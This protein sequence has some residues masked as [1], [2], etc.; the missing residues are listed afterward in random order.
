MRRRDD[1]VFGSSGFVRALLA[2]MLAV[3]G[4][5]GL[6]GCGT[7]PGSPSVQL[8]NTVDYRC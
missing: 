8:G 2:G 5:L 4:M 3:S 6:A 7:E 1:L